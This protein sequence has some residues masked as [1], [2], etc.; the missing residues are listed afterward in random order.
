MYI[1]MFCYCKRF[2]Y[3]DMYGLIQHS[4]GRLQN[5]RVAALRGEAE[6]D[7]DEIVPQTCYSFAN[8]LRIPVAMATASVN[9]IYS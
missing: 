6:T 9:L 4:M 5:R 7:D 3:N 8:R 2:S 1:I